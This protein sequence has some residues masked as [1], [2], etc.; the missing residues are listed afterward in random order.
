[1]STHTPVRV[2]VQ[3]SGNKQLNGEKQYVTSDL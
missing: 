3:L 1:M 2:L